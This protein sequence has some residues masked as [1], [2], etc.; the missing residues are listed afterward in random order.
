MFISLFIESKYVKSEWKQPLKS[1]VELCITVM[2]FSLSRLSVC[3]IC[4]CAGDDVIQTS[5][6]NI[7]MFWLSQDMMLTMGHLHLSPLLNYEVETFLYSSQLSTS[8]AGQLEVYAIN[9]TC[10]FK[11]R[12]LYSSRI[13]HSIQKCLFREAWVKSEWLRRMWGRGCLKHLKH[14]GVWHGSWWWHEFLWLPQWHT[15]YV[16]SRFPTL[17]NVVRQKTQKVC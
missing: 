1:G 13:I 3:L 17:F 12:W 4:S 11:Y 8:V 7:Q 10:V 2:G 14:T 9:S 16:T 6:A 5:S 15:C